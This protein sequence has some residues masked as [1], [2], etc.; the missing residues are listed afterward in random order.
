MD[1][2]EEI[3]EVGELQSILDLFESEIVSF[4]KQDGHHNRKEVKE[5]QSRY[6]DFGKKS[7]PSFLELDQA[8]FEKLMIQ[9]NDIRDR[10]LKLS[11]SRMSYILHKFD[12]K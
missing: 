11:K 1:V 7:Y 9:V 6:R 10:M 12:I 4:E 3:I 2:I 5:F 8:D